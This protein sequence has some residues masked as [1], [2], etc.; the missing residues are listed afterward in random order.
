MVKETSTLEQRKK[1]VLSLLKPHKSFLVYFVLAVILWVG[2]FVRTRGINNLKDVTTGLHVPLA[3]DPFV[4]LRYARYILEHGSIMTHDAMRYFPH[5]YNPA[6]EF[7]LLSHF[8]VYLYKFLHLFNA[9]IT[10]EYVH[11]LYPPIAFV[12]GLFFFFLLLRR[13]LDYRVALLATAFLSVIQPYIFRTTAGFSD[14]ESLGM[15]FFF[16]V[17][18]LFVVSFQTTSFKT[19]LF[20]SI[21]AGF[22]TGLM[23]LTWGGV[24]FLFLIIGI[25]SLYHM[26]F[27]EFDK[28]H[29]FSYAAWFLTTVISVS[30]IFTTRYTFSS[31]IFAETSSAMVLAF[32]LGFVNLLLLRY[33]FL[34]LKKRFLFSSF[35]LFYHP[36][37]IF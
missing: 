10:L 22:I 17:L 21:L 14:K 3:L 36:F 34:H 19:S 35:L 24:Q 30:F 11:I 9:D 2:F 12:A 16:V 4:F 37:F 33:D 23:A 18:Y 28:H 25:F 26:I 27:I 29:F 15:L 5:G 31:I 6:S 32:I 1:R 20:I 8:I 13:L 7:S